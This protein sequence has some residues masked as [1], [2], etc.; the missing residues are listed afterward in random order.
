[1]F[2]KMPFPF[3]KYVMSTVKGIEDTAVKEIDKEPVP[4]ELVFQWRRQTMSK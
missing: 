3:N 4:L 2:T 1:M